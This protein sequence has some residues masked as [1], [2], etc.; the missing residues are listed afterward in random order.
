MKGDTM[1]QIEL[2][3]FT[4]FQFL[5][6]LNISKDKGTLFFVVSKV[7]MENNGYLQK[8]VSYDVKTDTQKDV[9][10]WEKAVPYMILDDGVFFIKN[11]PEK[12]GVYSTF[13]QMKEEGNEEVFTVPIAVSM[14]KDLNDEYYVAASLTNRSC[15]DY[16]AL[17]DEEKEAQDQKVKDNEDYI[18]F[19]E[20]PFVFNGAGVVNG[21]RNSLFLINKK[22]HSVRKITPET[23][24]V[25]GFEVFENKVY[26]S[27]NDFTTYK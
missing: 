10:D 2:D 25:A 13:Y 4:S 14:M 27:A 11:D 9:T 19:D 3:Q 23:F 1:K 6:S 21:N 12:K 26:F 7:D 5:S 20:Y 17:S 22:D 16:Y 18:V 8:L 15:P 24:D